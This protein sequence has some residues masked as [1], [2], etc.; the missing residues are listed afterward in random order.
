MSAQEDFDRLVEYIHSAIESEQLEPAEFK[1]ETELRLRLVYSGLRRILGISE[2][3]HGASNLGNDYKI[4]EKTVRADELYTNADS[5]HE[6][7]YW[8]KIER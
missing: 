2:G 7:G 3:H 8:P 6:F 5:I 4:I 1:A